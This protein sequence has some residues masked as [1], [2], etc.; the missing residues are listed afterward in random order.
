MRK[1][2]LQSVDVLDKERAYTLRTPLESLFLQ[3]QV[4]SN[5]L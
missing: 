3:R 2:L 5:V 4:L 1:L